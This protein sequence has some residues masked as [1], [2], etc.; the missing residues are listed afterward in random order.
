MRK[1]ILV[2][3]ATLFVLFLLLVLYFS[4]L[5]PR[6]SK[7][8]KMD[9]FEVSENCP[10][11]C[12]KGISPGKTT[13]TEAR[14]ILQTSWDVDQRSFRSRNKNMYVNWFTERTRMRSADVWI[15]VENDVVQSITFGTLGPFQLEDFVSLLGEPELIEFEYQNY[16]RPLIKYTVHFHKYCLSLIVVTGFTRGPHPHDYI[17]NLTIR[18][19]VLC[20]PG[21]DENE[22]IQ[23][24]LGYGRLDEYLPGYDFPA[25]P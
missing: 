16:G 5:Q 11:L 14:H 4:V 9:A 20:S 19:K 2:L 15:L 25:S 1:K 23:P 13:Y 3:S 18:N 8:P 17:G 22:L 12:W 24:W 7:I 21:F 6:W 10:Y